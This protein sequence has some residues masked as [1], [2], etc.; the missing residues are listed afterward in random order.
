MTADAAQGPQKRAAYAEKGVQIQVLL[1]SRSISAAGDI[2]DFETS[3]WRF[4]CASGPA[5]REQLLLQGNH[6][7]SYIWDGQCLSQTFR[8]KF[9]LGMDHG[10]D[11]G[12][13]PETHIFHLSIGKATITL[14]DMEVLF[15]LPVDGLPVAYPH[16]LRDYRGLH[17]LH[18]LQ[19]LTGFQPVEETALS[20]ASR[21]Q[22][23][24]V[25]HH[26]EMMDAEIMDDSP[27]KDI[28]RHTRLLLLLMFS[29]VLFPNT[30][31]NLIS[32]RFLHHLERLDNLPGYSW[33]AVVI[34]YL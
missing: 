30:S 14:E 20:R 26:L 7:S 19:R 3:S 17:Y 23:T 16:A 34:D 4:P 8:P 10:Y 11:S 22:L 31:G 32:L 29:G 9:R 18:M 15:G 21:L 12:W 27:S 28:D 13:R 24:P 6:R 33:S 2:R 5:S 25:R 1:L